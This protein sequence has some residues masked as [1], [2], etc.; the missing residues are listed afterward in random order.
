[1]LNVD[2]KISPIDNS[3]EGF[4]PFKVSPPLD[5]S[6]NSYLSMN[7]KKESLNNLGGFEK[8]AANV[9]LLCFLKKYCFQQS[10]V[11]RRLICAGLGF[12]DYSI[13]CQQILTKEIVQGQES[14]T[15]TLL[16]KI[17]SQ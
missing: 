1:M 13:L 12:V 5:I 17:R 14:L 11:I 16:S 4:S 2:E 15:K 8:P 7:R 6:S 3:C 10:S 9:L